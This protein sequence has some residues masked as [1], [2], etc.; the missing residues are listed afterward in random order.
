MAKQKA[1]SL[2][3]GLLGA[4]D[5]KPDAHTGI[6]NKPVAMTLKL[7]HSDYVQL[8]KVAAERKTNGQALMLEAVREYLAR[9]G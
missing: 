9:I 8:R 5:K 1:K 6:D 2:D 3:A 4:H 7:P